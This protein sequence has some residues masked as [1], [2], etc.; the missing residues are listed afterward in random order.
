[1][2]ISSRDQRVTIHPYVASNDGGYTT[3]GYGA[4]RG[5]YHCRIS[6]LS[7]DEQTIAEQADHKERCIFDFA[8]SVTVDQNDLLIDPL[9]A[10]W[11]VEGVLLRRNNGQRA[12]IVRAFR[13]IDE[14]AVVPA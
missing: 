6:P 9:S 13:N 4:A 10:Q 11:K 5:T 7:A 2:S 3:S 1:M 14:P 12:K 8:D